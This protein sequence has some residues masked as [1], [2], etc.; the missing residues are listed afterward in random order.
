M[1]TSDI[2]SPLGWPGQ[3]AY[4]TRGSGLHRALPVDAP[5]CTCP[6][7]GAGGA[8]LSAHL[9]PRAPCMGG[10]IEHPSWP[11]SRS[12]LRT[13]CTP[14][15]RR[16]W[17]PK[18][19]AG[20]HNY[21]P[22]L[23]RRRDKRLLLS[24]K[25]LSKQIAL[26]ALRTR[27]STVGSGKCGALTI[28]LPLSGTSCRSTLQSAHAY[29]RAKYC[30]TQDWRTSGARQDATVGAWRRRRGAICQ[31]TWASNTFVAGPCR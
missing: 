28:F 2:Y 22:P 7:P 1:R 19:Q 23:C 26:G 24:R 20:L 10:N 29:Q 11:A 13:P 4:R 3:R 18:R 15:R 6:M 30:R 12:E 31:R 21:A 14:R 16:A 8:A 5:S 25:F 9:P 27:L 17:Q